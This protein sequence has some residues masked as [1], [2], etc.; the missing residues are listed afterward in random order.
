[1]RFERQRLLPV[2]YK[3]VPVARGY[4]LDFVVEDAVVVEVKAVESLLP[5]HEAQL[6][7]YLKL[8]RLRTGLLVN[9]HSETIRSAVRRLSLEPQNLP[10]S[11]PPCEI[12]ERAEDR[13]GSR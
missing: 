13:K 9:F 4:R 3:G 10:A 6:L 2:V 7:T 11:P 8:T 12:Q 5:V 1:L